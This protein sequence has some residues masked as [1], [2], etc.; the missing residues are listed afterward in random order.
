MT[1]PTT[2]V[3]MFFDM[4]NRPDATERTRPKSFYLDKGRQTLKLNF[5]MV[6]FCDNSTF[7]DVKYIACHLNL[8]LDQYWLGLG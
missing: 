7:E 2:V 5:P 3:T 8:I 1:S 4:K 6:V